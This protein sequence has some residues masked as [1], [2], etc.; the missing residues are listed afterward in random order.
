MRSLLRTV[1]L[2][3]LSLLFASRSFHHRDVEHDQFLQDLQ[4]VVLL[5]VLHFVVFVP[6]VQLGIPNPFHPLRWLSGILLSEIAQH[7]HR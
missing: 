4:L 3:K 2:G 1:P 7:G 5:F 6:S